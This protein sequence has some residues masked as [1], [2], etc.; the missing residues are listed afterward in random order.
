MNKILLFISGYGLLGL[1]YYLYKGSS[2][3]FLFCCFAMMFAVSALC[4]ASRV[5]DK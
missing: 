5:F 1:G 4:Y 2:D 3:P